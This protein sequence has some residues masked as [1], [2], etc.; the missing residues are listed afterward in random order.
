MWSQSADYSDIRFL[1]HVKREERRTRRTNAGNVNG[2]RVVKKRQDF[3]KHN[4]MGKEFSPDYNPSIQG[5]GPVKHKK[6][7]KQHKKMVGI[8]SQQA[9][10]QL[11]TVVEKEDTGTD[12]QNEAVSRIIYKYLILNGQSKTDNPEKLANK[13]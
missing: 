6:K 1:I 13:R 5:D 9:S 11:Q 12:Q 2:P 8:S 4:P 7:H 10:K 3:L